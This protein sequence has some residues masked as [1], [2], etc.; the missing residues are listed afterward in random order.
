MIDQEALGRGSETCKLSDFGATLFYHFAFV[1][2]KVTWLAFEKHGMINCSL[3]QPRGT[4]TT[5]TK[6]KY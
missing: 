1:I 6:N 4:T 3:V 2:C 5:I